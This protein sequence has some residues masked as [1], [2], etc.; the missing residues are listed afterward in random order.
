MVASE[1]AEQRGVN[2]TNKKV[3]SPLVERLLLHQLLMD[4]RIDQSRRKDLTVMWDAFERIA[5]VALGKLKN[6]MWG[7]RRLKKPNMSTEG[8]R[9]L[10]AKLANHG[11]L[12]AVRTC[13]G[14]Q[15][16]LGL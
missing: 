9:T 14:S 2:G 10:S 7:P 11:D 3:L 6:S 16:S 15:N 13:R 12:L 1:H 8:G 4:V 5:K